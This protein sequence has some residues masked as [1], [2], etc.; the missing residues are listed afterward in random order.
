METKEMEKE[1][2]GAVAGGLEEYLQQLIACLPNYEETVRCIERNADTFGIDA[3]FKVGAA[4]HI[5]VCRDR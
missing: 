4:V 1:M 2:E 3:R 5:E